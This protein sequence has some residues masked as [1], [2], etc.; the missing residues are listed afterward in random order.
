MYRA[1]TEHSVETTTT[2]KVIPVIDQYGVP[3]YDPATGRALIARV[4]Q[5]TVEKKRPPVWQAAMALLERR[6]PERWARRVIRQDFAKDMGPVNIEMI[7]DDGKGEDKK[8]HAAGAG[9]GRIR[10][11]V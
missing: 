11:A 2:R 1:F 8:K 9:P 6:H 3:Q 10:Q 5:I 4:E 7:F